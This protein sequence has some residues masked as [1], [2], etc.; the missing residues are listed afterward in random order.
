[1]FSGKAYLAAMKGWTGE[2]TRR[3]HEE[4]VV[5]AQRRE[6]RPDLGLEGPSERADQNTLQMYNGMYSWLIVGNQ[7]RE[8][9]DF[10]SL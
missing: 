6:L 2:E 10:N 4:V 8:I 1:M 9:L 3:P 7:M 5:K